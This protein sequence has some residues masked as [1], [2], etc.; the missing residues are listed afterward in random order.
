MASR[1]DEL[2]KEISRLVNYQRAH[3]PKEVDNRTREQVSAEQTILSTAELDKV[4]GSVAKDKDGHGL[5]SDTVQYAKKFCYDTVDAV[6]KLGENRRFFILQ[7][8]NL[9]GEPYVITKF[10]QLLLN[11]GIET[12]KGL[13][14]LFLTTFKSTH[15]VVGMLT[16]QDWLFPA[17]KGNADQGEL[18]VF[19]S[20]LARMLL[21]L[22]PSDFLQ[23]QASKHNVEDIYPIE[24][25]VKIVQKNN[26]KQL[27]KAVIGDDNTIVIIL[28]DYMALLQTHYA[29]FIYGLKRY[30]YLKHFLVNKLRQQGTLERLEPA[31]V[32]KLVAGALVG[33][34]QLTPHDDLIHDLIRENRFHR[35]EVI[36]AEAEFVD[37]LTP[38]TLDKVI[39][40]VYSMIKKLSKPSA[41]LDEAFQEVRQLS[42]RDGFVA[43]L[44][45]GFMELV[46][47]GLIAASDLV[48]DIRN[49]FRAKFDKRKKAQ[50]EK[51]ELVRVKTLAQ[52]KIL[53]SLESLK[54]YRMVTTDKLG[55][56]GG[57]GKTIQKDFAETFKLFKDDEQMV[58]Y[59]K[60]CFFTLFRFFEEHP[61]L[62]KVSVIEQPHPSGDEEPFH[63]WYV[64]FRI[65][66]LNDR[67]MLGQPHLLC[68]GLTN[69]P[70]QDRA[71]SGPVSAYDA[72]EGELD[73]YVI[74]F[75][76]NPT[77]Q[78]SGRAISRRAEGNRRTFNQLPI[79]DDHMPIVYEALHDILH[80]LP[81]EE[82]A[83]WNAEEVQ[84]CLGFLRRSIAVPL[85]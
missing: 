52:P 85:Q 50:A 34:E 53:S 76:G 62:S 41:D 54:Q 77:P 72:Y 14:C 8:I 66:N 59:F 18:Y 64:A 84:F 2:T 5:T 79:L 39:Q 57:E 82:Q 73:P 49:S 65:P 26:L 20:D 46:E 28:I 30:E 61:E 45:A 60:K 78:G 69:F 36:A 37:Q 51:R 47:R 10:I 25:L 55:Y 11:E 4:F 44:H 67:L 81:E 19:Q 24:F 58:F 1:S 16:A 74:L 23:S 17:P 43:K 31:D 38:N 56:R 40:Q 75:V 9:F 12:R 22:F 27:Q 80:L 21:K 7:T 15:N 70:R 83:Y 68:L 3:R 35:S 42:E 29:L 71:V 63:E 13:A 48:R 33:N 6:N 32:S